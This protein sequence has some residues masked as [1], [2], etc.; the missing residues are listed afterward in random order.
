MAANNLD[1]QITYH[2]LV[3]K[4]KARSAIWAH[5]GF[6]ANE[7]GEIL[8]NQVV[9]C[10]I[11][12]D[13]IKYSNNTTNLK[14]HLA[15]KHPEALQR[16]ET[17]SSASSS[18]KRQ[19]NE[20]LTT[21]VS[22]MDFSNIIESSRTNFRTNSRTNSSSSS[23]TSSQLMTRNS[24]SLKD[25]ISHESNSSNTLVNVPQED[26]MQNETIKQSNTSDGLMAQLI[27]CL[28]TDFIVP[29]EIYGPGF[30]SFLGSIL[31]DCVVPNIDQVYLFINELI[32]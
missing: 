15:N 24:F 21:N 9:V 7:K 17:E 2:S 22:T 18:P 8:V 20:E 10:T 14:Q 27:N 11:C 1:G 29:R 4:Q 30:Q 25:G 28:T 26:E 6:P 31:P 12:M 16:C 5:F 32:L 3:T 13:A 19:K 23:R